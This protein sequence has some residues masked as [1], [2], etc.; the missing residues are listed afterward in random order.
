M[1]FHYN[2]RANFLPLSLCNSAK[3]VFQNFPNHVKDDYPQTVAMLCAKYDRP[4]IALSQLIQ[5]I[6]HSPESMVQYA[7][8]FTKLSCKLASLSPP[9][10]SVIRSS[11]NANQSCLY[12]HQIKSLFIQSNHLLSRKSL[13]SKSSKKESLFKFGS[14]LQNLLFRRGLR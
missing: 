3:A 6:Q 11:E 10:Q 5:C 2:Q 9:P 13:Q 4:D 1:G 12:L 8:E 7:S 14:R